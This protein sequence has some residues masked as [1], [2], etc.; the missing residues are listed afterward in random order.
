MSNASFDLSR[1][2][3]IELIKV[4][5]EPASVQYFDGLGC[6]AGRVEKRSADIG[7]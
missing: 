3:V 7:L 2:N 1:L 5:A 6:D 4:R